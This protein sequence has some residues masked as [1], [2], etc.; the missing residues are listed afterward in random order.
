MR[1]HRFDIWSFVPG[2]ALSAFGLVV[3]LGGVDV[4]DWNFSWAAPAVFILAGLALLLG[5]R[6]R[7][8]PEPPDAEPN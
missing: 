5:A 3:L 1:R 4:T 7:R 8:E 6:N 2:L